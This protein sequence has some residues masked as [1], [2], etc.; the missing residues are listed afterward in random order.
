LRFVLDT[1]SQATVLNTASADD[2]GYSASMGTKRSRLLGVEGVQEG[3]RLKVDRLE[4]LGF[5]VENHEVFCHDFDE[6]LGVDGLIGMDLLA[7]RVL[8]I[9]GVKGLIRIGRS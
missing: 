2:N 5:A 1:G 6:R 9:D 8:T 7:G 4:A 3:Y